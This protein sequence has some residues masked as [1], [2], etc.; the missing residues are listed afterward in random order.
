MG[1]ILDQDGIIY[2]ANFGP[3]NKSFMDTGMESYT[4]LILD[5]DNEAYT[6]PNLDPDLELDLDSD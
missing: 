3:D 1:S 5:P 2:G 6:D 4:D